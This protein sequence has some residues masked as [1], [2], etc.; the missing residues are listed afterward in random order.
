M[1]LEPKK[2]KAVT[3][4][5]K[6]SN[7][8]LCLVLTSF[9][10][11]WLYEFFIY[12]ECFTHTHTHT[13]IIPLLD[14]FE[15]PLVFSWLPFHFGDRFSHMQKLFSVMSNLFISEFVSLPLESN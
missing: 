4:S 2:I 9:F 15:Y 8:I 5:T 14:I 7:H 13:H 11:N 12:F 3:A 6:L 1:T 10:L